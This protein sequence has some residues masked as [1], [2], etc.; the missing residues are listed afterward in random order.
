[1]W[2]NESKITQKLITISLNRNDEFCPI[3]DGGNFPYQQKQQTIRQL[4]YELPL[5][6]GGKNLSTLES[7]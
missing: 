7:L 4:I 1:M 5:F 6:Y 2:H 3:C